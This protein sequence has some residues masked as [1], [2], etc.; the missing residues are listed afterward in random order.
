MEI[1]KTTIE[2]TC[3]RLSNGISNSIH[4]KIELACSS[5]G[6]FICSPL[7]AGGP[8]LNRY[9]PMALERLRLGTLAY[10]ANWWTKHLYA[11]LYL[12]EILNT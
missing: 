10:P 9:G 11:R 6:R 12:F 1:L 3:S 5:R 8:R 4:P 2:T 7:I